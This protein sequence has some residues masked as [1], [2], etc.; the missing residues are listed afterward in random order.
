[1]LQNFGALKGITINKANGSAKVYI[2]NFGNVA[3]GGGFGNNNDYAIDLV[4]NE[5]WLKTAGTWA[6][7]GISNR[8]DALESGLRWLPGVRVYSGTLTEAN[9]LSSGATIS[10]FEGGASFTF[11]SGQRVALGATG[12]IY[13]FDGTVWAEWQPQNNL[14]TGDTFITQNY[15]P[16]IDTREK[17]LAIVQYNGTAFIKLSDIDFETADSISFSNYVVSGVP[18]SAAYPV[19]TDSIEGAI[20]KFHRIMLNFEAQFGIPFNTANIGAMSGATITSNTTVKDALQEIVNKTRFENN[21]SNITTS[22]V[23]DTIAV[24]QAKS[25]Q[26]EVQVIVAADPTRTYSLVIN[27]LTNGTTADWSESNIREIGT[28]ING[29]AFSVDVVATNLRLLASSSEAVNITATR[30]IIGK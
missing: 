21:L 23:L 9:L 17:G 22:T 29:L 24:A 7:T 19:S 15:L 10:S 14:R 3:P 27:A 28:I 30:R 6:K 8:V 20:L 11:T 2:E 16:D 26:W 1:M 13:E 4:T 18:T 12:K 5:I 25:V